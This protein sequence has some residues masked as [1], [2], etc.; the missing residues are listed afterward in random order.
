MSAYPIEIMLNDETQILLRP[1]R[2]EDLQDLIRFFSGVPPSDLLMFTNDSKEPGTVENWFKD[3]GCRNF[4][5]IIALHNGEIVAEGKI[6]QN[7]LRLRRVGELKLIVNPAYRGKGLGSQ[8]F[9]ILLIEG[10]KHEIRI[11]TI[12]FNPD[13]KSFLK[14]LTRYGLK[15]ETVLRSTI[16]KEEYGNDKELVIASCNL[17]DWEGRFT[18]YNLIHEGE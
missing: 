4:P 7:G 12:R 2:E 13:D 3:S 5:R 6:Y 9:K 8:M 16:S 18:F 15:L 14:I 10:L 11:L 1:E 17:E